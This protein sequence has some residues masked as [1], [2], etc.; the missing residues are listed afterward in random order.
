MVPDQDDVCGDYHTVILTEL[1]NSVVHNSVFDEVVCVH[2][3]LS[4]L[5]PWE[6]SSRKG[7]VPVLVFSDESSQR[8][9]DLFRKGLAVDNAESKGRLHRYQSLINAFLLLLKIRKGG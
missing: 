3:L 6:T 7:A 1:A 4:G 8:F 2:Y 5:I 9:L